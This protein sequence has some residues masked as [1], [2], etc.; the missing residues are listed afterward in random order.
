[1]IETSRLVLREWREADRETFRSV[2]NT[3]AVMRYF[4]GVKA[5]IDC[6]A[7]FDKRIADQARHGMSYWAVTLKAD[8]TIIGTC[9]VRIADNYPPDLPIHNKV[10]A[11][12]RIGERWWRQGFAIEAASAS[13]AWLWNY[14][15]AADVLGWT[16]RPNLPSQQ[17]MVK[18]GMARRPDFD[19]DHP[20]ISSRSELRR[21]IA[22]GINRPS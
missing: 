2:I 15:N 1:M 8:A 11:G 16:S 7:L 17:L 22:F 5:M 12:W 3:P 21:H 19:F 10:E 14:R 4:G 9:G 6:D 20:S 18:L 13:I